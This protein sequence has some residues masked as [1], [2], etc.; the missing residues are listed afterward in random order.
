MLA[1]ISTA[2]VKDLRSKLNVIDV[3]FF[4]VKMGSDISRSKMI[5]N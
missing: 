2:L 5:I 1:F 3:W 4:R